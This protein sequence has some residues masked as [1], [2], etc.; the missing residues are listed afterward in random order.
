M[1]AR[2]SLTGTT[3]A[4]QPP[5]PGTLVLFA[6]KLQKAIERGYFKE[7]DFWSLLDMFDVPKGWDIRVINNGTL[8][9]LNTALWAPSLFL[10]SGNAALRVMTFATFML[11]VD[12]G[13]LFLNF[14]MHKF[15]HLYA[16]IAIHHFRKAF[17]GNDVAHFEV[18]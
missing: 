4:Q 2:G 12:I 11:D 3:I 10:T 17:Q 18:V 1:Y 15:I 7:G 16:G 14:P 8:L 5:K 6:V 9:G 13:E